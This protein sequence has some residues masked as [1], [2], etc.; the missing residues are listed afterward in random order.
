[1]KFGLL[2]LAV[3]LGTHLCASLV[4][5]S[6]LAPQASLNWFFYSVLKGH[7][8]FRPG[9]LYKLSVVLAMGGS[10]WLLRNLYLRRVRASNVDKRQ[11]TYA[12]WALLASVI[13]SMVCIHFDKR[14]EH[15]GRLVPLAL[16]FHSVGIVSLASGV[17]FVVYGGA[18]SLGKISGN[19]RRAFA[20]AAA[21]LGGLLC[22]VAAAIM[23]KVEFR[24]DDDAQVAVAAMFGIGVPL[25]VA[26]VYFLVA[27]RE[28][29]PVPVTVAA[30][31]E[32]KSVEE[33]LRILDDLFKK[34]LLTRAEY[35]SRREEIV[36]AL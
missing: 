29:N 13:L 24:Y 27:K 26:G 5:Q 6:V 33:R 7:S 32:G 11:W 36:S 25:L 20:G 28:N 10:G 3:W 14:F 21:A 22:I 2:A 23:S 15:A 17:F 16:V 9:A 18:G 35:T 8:L 34:G 12:I 4:F 1:L 19:K 31:V 30:V